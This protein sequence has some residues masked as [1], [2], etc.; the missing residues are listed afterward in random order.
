MPTAMHD[1]AA[2]NGLI[3]A[4]SGRYVYVFTDGVSSETITLPNVYGYTC[5]TSCITFNNGLFIITGQMVG[6]SWSANLDQ[7]AVYAAMST[8][9]KTWTEWVHVKGQNDQE[10]QNRAFA[11]IVM[12]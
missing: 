7:Y 5:S 4:T 10:L 11:M 2:G 1:I 12:P 9:G 3:I 8:A 6:S